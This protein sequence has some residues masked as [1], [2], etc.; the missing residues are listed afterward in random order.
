M[1][2]TNLQNSLNYWNGLLEMKVFEKSDKSVV[3]GYKDNEAKLELVQL[4]GLYNLL[5]YVFF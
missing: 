1:A 2:S 3:V 4:G 5:E